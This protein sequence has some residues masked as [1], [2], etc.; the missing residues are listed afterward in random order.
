MQNDKLETISEE[1]LDSVSGG[2]RRGIGAV[3]GGVIDGVLDVAGHIVGGGL[4][5]LGGL[6]SG[7]GGLLS[8]RHH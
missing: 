8:G 3:V 4:S 6:L 1:M 2:H 5:A 7:L